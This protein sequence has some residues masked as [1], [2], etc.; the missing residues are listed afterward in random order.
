MRLFFC[1][2][3]DDISVVIFPPRMF[4]DCYGLGV[5]IFVE[6]VIYLCQTLEV[7]NEPTAPTPAVVAH[8]TALFL[9]Q[10]GTPRKY[11][12]ITGETNLY[13]MIVFAV[14]VHSPWLSL[15]A[16]QFPVEHKGRVFYF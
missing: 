1:C 10:H 8:G 2:I 3:G 13:M 5:S 14:L 7:W 9:G 11:S 12:E 16:L 15:L 4:C 6:T